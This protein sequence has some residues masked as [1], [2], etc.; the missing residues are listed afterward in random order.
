MLSILRNSQLVPN[1]STRSKKQVKIAMAP[2]QNLKNEKLKLEKSFDQPQVFEQTEKKSLKKMKYKKIQQ[3]LQNS[4]PLIPDSVLNLSH[5][6]QDQLKF[7][8]TKNVPMTMPLDMPVA[9]EVKK[10][11]NKKS[12]KVTKVKASP[13][14]IK[15]KADKAEKANVTEQE[16]DMVKAKKILGDLK[17]KGVVYYEVQFSGN[18]IEPKYIKAEKL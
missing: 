12:N 6:Q 15:E 4:T 13:A 1:K 8:L 7:L 16:V 3:L 5:Q 9:D 10:T 14:K 11:V 17:K 2:A 18:K